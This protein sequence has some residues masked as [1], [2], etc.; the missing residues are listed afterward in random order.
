MSLS[1]VLGSTGVLSK[2]RLLPRLKFHELYPSE[3][4]RIQ[5]QSH[6]LRESAWSDHIKSSAAHYSTLLQ[7]LPGITTQ[8]HLKENQNIAGLVSALFAI[9]PEIRKAVGEALG[10]LDNGYSSFHELNSAIK[11]CLAS[12]VVP[13]TVNIQTGKK[14]EDTTTVHPSPLV[15]LNSGMEFY[16]VRVN[17]LI[18]S[19]PREDENLY[20]RRLHWI[21]RIEEWVGK[22]IE[23]E[24]LTQE[25]VDGDNIENGN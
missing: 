2:E 1:A 11:T 20:P 4:F 3:L 8:D 9:L 14:P 17:D 19:I 12:S 16:L 15:L 10:E 22:A 13:S 24:Y 7:A 6:F 23:D 5:Q 18:R 21:R 25:A